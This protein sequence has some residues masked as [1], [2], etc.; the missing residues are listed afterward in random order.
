M[1]LF[2]RGQKLAEMDDQGLRELG[3]EPRLHRVTIMR[4][5]D[6]LMA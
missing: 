6:E 3:V 2:E 5:R 1:T 4:L